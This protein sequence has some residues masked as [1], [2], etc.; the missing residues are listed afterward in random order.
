[1]AS[2]NALFGGKTD[3]MRKYHKCTGSE[4]IHF[5]DI[6]SVYPMVLRDL[7]VPVRAPKIHIGPDFP[8]LL[9]TER[10]VKYLILPPRKLYHPV[11]PIKMLSKLTFVLCRKCAEQSINENCPHN[12]PTDRALDGTWVIDE[13][14]LALQYGYN[15][16]EIYYGS[17]KIKLMIVEIEALF[18]LT[19]ST[20]S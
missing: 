6:M 7:K 16:L 14:R 11:L 3:G 9:I 4:K 10:L 13:V 8:S 12:D 2:R 17:M 20:L 19:M 18:S 1:M 15:V 5:V